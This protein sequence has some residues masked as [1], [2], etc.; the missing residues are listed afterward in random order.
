M[1][2]KEIGPKQLSRALTAAVKPV[3]RCGEKERAT[4]LVAELGACPVLPFP[5]SCCL[6]LRF[7]GDYRVEGEHRHHP[8]SPPVEH[9]RSSPLFKEQQPKCFPQSCSISNPPERARASQGEIFFFFFFRA[10][11]ELLVPCAALRLQ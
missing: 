3:A 10:G 9:Y 4:G 7:R 2:E 11:K 5:P 1:S 6:F 8:A